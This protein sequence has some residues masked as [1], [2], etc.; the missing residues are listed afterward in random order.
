MKLPVAA[1]HTLFSYLK[2]LFTD[3]FIEEIRQN[4]GTLAYFASD[5][6]RG[7]FHWDKVLSAVK[8]IT[9]E[10]HIWKGG[11]LSTVVVYTKMARGE[12]ARYIKKNRMTDP[13]ALKA[14]SWEGF[15]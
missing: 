10:F 15:E 13:E 4:G 6:I 14:F 11:K 8:V 7:L 1:N 9:P 12:M 5:E 3:L 2:D